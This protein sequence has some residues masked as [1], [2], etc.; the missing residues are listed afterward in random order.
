MRFDMRIVAKALAI[1]LAAACAATTLAPT[2][3]L[4]TEA[5]DEAE[6]T[7]LQRLQREVERTAE[8]YDEALAVVE[9]LDAK[10]AENEARIAELE[11][12]IPVQRA[13]ASE[14]IAAHYKL[15][16]ETPGIVELILSSDSFNEFISTITYLDIIADRS[17]DELAQLIAM[18]EELEAVRAEL[19]AQKEEADARLAEAENALAEAQA[20]REAAQRAAEERARREAAA[21]AAAAQAAAQAAAAQQTYTN[22]SGE[23]VPAQ[24]PSNP[25]APAPSSIS[26]A[27]DKESFVAEWAPR[28][29]AYL[30]GSPLGGH[31]RTFAEAAWDYGVD[32]RV[33]PAIAAVE[34]GKGRSCYRSYNAWGWGGISWPDW[35]TAIR[36]HVAGFASGYGYTVSLSGAASYCPPTYQ[37]WYSSVVAEMERI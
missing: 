16:Q 29:D 36:A 32:P 15:Q 25:S 28:I 33:S 18:E 27:T 3:T 37:L 12:Q 21:A 35:D 5:E 34:S 14:A 24:A 13:R 7:E 17:T 8:E 22:E 23:Q 19:A 4:A 20:A 10:I 6:Q 31:G 1:A 26:W 2:V 11:D 9:E 30:G